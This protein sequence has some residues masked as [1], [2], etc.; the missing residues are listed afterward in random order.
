MAPMSA[1]LACVCVC[2]SLQ[3]WDDGGACRGGERA[4]GVEHWSHKGRSEAVKM[5]MGPS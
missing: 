1:L 2:A 5:L 3:Y 4:Q